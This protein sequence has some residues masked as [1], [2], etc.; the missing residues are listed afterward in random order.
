MNQ[1]R[2][3]IEP[4]IAALLSLLVPGLGQMCQGRIIAGPIAFCVTFIGYLF[5]ILPGL[6]F[7]LITIVDAALYDQ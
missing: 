5:F 3:G 7:H 4:G 1:R 2:R 6:F